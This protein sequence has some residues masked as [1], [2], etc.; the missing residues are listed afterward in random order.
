MCDVLALYKFS[1]EK[2]KT[3]CLVQHSTD[4]LYCFADLNSEER[5]QAPCQCN[6]AGHQPVNRE[7]FRTCMNSS[8][9]LA[10][11]H[12]TVSNK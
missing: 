9:T 7:T 5:L 6:S 2:I 10:P 11:M 12:K 3:T 8:C 1:D 4:P